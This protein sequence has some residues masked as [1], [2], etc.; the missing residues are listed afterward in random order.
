MDLIT[1]SNKKVKI[2][3]GDLE[4]CDQVPQQAEDK[5]GKPK[6]KVSYRETLLGH[7]L[8]DATIEDQCDRHSFYAYDDSES[9][10][11]KGD[12]DCPNIRR[13]REE[14]QRIR[15]P[16]LKTLILKVLV[17]RIGFKFLKRR[18]IQLWNPKGI[19]SLADL[20]NDYFLAHFIN[21]EDYETSLLI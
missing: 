19:V 2:K 20:D 13:S 15:K 16:W 11:E 17:K 12:K 18:V 10:N 7:E 8:Y 6:H 5:E 21:D 3:E 9:E 4:V 14:R 1:R